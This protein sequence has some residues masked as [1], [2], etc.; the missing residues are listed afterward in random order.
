MN[1]TYYL[2]SANTLPFAEWVQVLH[3]TVRQEAFLASRRQDEPNE[4][5]TRLFRS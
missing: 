5:T 3:L 1:G 4:R 2:A